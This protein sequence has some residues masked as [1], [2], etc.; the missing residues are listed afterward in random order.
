MRSPSMRIAWSFKTRPPLISINRPA[1]MSR[2]SFAG[3]CAEDDTLQDNKAKMRSTESQPADFFMTVIP[4]Y[5]TE[6]I[7]P[8]SLLRH[9][10][11]RKN[12]LPERCPLPP[13]IGELR[14]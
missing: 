5:L 9:R 1:L 7:I 3:D 12:R 14:F 4:L 13:R 8:E 6:K 11:L 10:P 2:V